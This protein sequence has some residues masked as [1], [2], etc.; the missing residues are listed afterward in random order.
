MIRTLECPNCGGPVEIKYERTLNAV[1]VQ[2]LSI[3]DA[4]TPG[5]K[6]LQLANSAQR[7]HPKIP[8]G[9]RGKLPSGEYEA[10]GFQVRQIKV[11][12]V[13]YSWSEYLLF[14]AYKGYRY[15]TEYNGH[16][17]DIRTLRA[18]PVPSTKGSK[19]AVLYNGIKFT[20][21]QT[22]HAM[23]AFV[24]GEFPWQVRIGETVSVQDFIAPPATLSSEESK[25]EIVWS[26]GSYTPGR[27][28]W[29]AFN[30]K[31]TP[32]ATI[33]I[34]ANQPS[35]FSGR[36]GSSWKLFAALVILLLATAALTGILSAREE[37]FRQRYVFHSG[38]G[39]PSFV[40]PVFR[41][42]DRQ[43]SLKIAIDTD[44]TNDWVYI[45]MAL[46]N[47]DT[48]IAY[49]FGKELSYYSGSDGDGSW[50]EGSKRGS[51]TIPP[52]PA[53]PYYLRVEPE[54]VEP[55]MNKT[56]SRAINYELVVTQG[57][58]TFF[59]FIL[60][61][62]GLLIP[63]VVTSIRAFSFENRRWA[64]SDYGALISSGAEEEE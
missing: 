63:P 56:A 52:A 61:F 62:A 37:V 31:G 3:L 41:L 18:L 50:T 47:D 14:N 5:L 45:S 30:L 25:D 49:D 32:P 33:G 7:H 10:I 6:I 11:E 59:W 24:M 57:S 44:L 60:G 38:S 55:E 20:H 2:C 53:G 29:K 46:I 42:K 1:C 12:G 51:V 8:L 13:I 23:T 48:G 36:V 27:A 15:L 58:P 54:R 39:E 34:Y 35:P 40:T 19:R 22:A 16:W 26:I 43:T 4:S 9:S 21:F 17:N 28:I 64:E